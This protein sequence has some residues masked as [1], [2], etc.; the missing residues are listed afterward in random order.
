M[1]VPLFPALGQLGNFARMPNLDSLE[2]PSEVTP[3]S[4]EVLRAWIVD[5]GLVCSL[6]PTAWPDSSTW[7]ILLAD[8]ARHVADGVQETD[9]TCHEDTLRR[10]WHI[11]NTEL[12]FPTDSPSGRLL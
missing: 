12:G 10:I 8:V 3:G 6:L 4:T 5:G 11:F 1:S 9:G 2:I 7:G